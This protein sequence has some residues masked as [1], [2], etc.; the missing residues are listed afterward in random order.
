MITVSICKLFNCVNKSVPKKALACV[1]SITSSLSL[2]PIWLVKSLHPLSGFKILRSGSFSLNTDASN[3]SLYIVVVK[4]TG[5]DFFLNSSINILFCLISSSHGNARGES[6][7]INPLAKS[8]TTNARFFP[9]PVFLNSALTNQ[10][11]LNIGDAGASSCVSSRHLDF[12]ESKSPPK[13]NISGS[14]LSDLIDFL[15]LSVSLTSTALSFI[16]TP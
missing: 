14:L 15:R 16:T 11:T 12:I 1:F 9:I 10:L 5:I 6:G 2:G 3:K 8:T 7:S 4:I 13:S